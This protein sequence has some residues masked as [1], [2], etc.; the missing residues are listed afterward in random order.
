MPSTQISKLPKIHGMKRLSA[1]LLA[2]IVAMTSFA[3]SAKSDNTLLWKVSGNGIEK[4]SY[5]FGTVH[6]ICKEDA[7]LSQNLR[8]AIE[9]AD[10]IYLEL[11]MDNLFFEA[12]GSINNMKMANDTTLADLLTPEEYKRVKKY[13]EKNAS[14]IPFSM[15]ET[16][17]PMLASA[18]LM[19]ATGLCDEQVAI[20]TLVME[21]AKKNKKRIDGLETM[22]YQMSIFDSI[23][24]KLQA[25]E[26]V[27]SISG[28]ANEESGL[29][30]FKE[31]I[32]AYKKQDLDKLNS[33]ISSS[34][35]QLMRYDDLL[36]GNRNR[37]WVIK[38]KDILSS[39]SVVV[40]VGAGHLPGN[41][42][43]INLLRKEGYTVTPVDNT[44]SAP[45]KT[46]EI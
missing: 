30:E 3:Q 25:Q 8:K 26:L 43:L 2:S 11:D 28:D 13:F 39:K 38:L 32:D 18:L 29:K 35:A 5:L 27:K 16:Y 42:G 45:V 14:M 21:E 10:R 23:P 9:N 34:D 19:E 37:N 31:L 44:K 17:K 24:Y 1:S 4:P 6:A 41:K 7:F 15:L 12:I 40:A 33:L 36:L 22:A 46:R 20:E